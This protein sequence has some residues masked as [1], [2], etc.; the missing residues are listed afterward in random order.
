[1]FLI[2]ACLV[3]VEKQSN[4]REDLEIEL[5]LIPINPPFSEYDRRTFIR[6][7]FKLRLN[8]RQI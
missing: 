6:A 7:E 2:V 3:I 4:N 5:P 1:M 8:E